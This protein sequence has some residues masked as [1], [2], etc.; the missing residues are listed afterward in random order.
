MQG[1]GSEK[2]VILESTIP[3]GMFP[4]RPGQGDAALATGAALAPARRR[5]TSSREDRSG[6]RM[7]E[8]IAALQA[9]LG[10]YMI[11]TCTAG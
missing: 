3:L 6:V 5:A 11:Y 8:R 10:S 9:C 1:C 2:G 4:T 7:A